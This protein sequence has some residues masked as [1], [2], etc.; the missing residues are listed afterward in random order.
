VLGI[1]S[2]QNT[3]TL[4]STYPTLGLL[5]IFLFGLLSCSVP[6]TQITYADEPAKPIE[7]TIL[8]LNDVYEIAPLEG[9]KVGGLA[10]VATVL[11]RLEAENPNTIAVMAGD[12]LSP[13]F[14]GTLRKNG[15]KVAGQQ[16]IE[17][18][19]ILGLDYATFG[20]HEFDF[21]SLELLESRIDMSDFAYVSTNA[22]VVRP[23]AGPVPFTQRGVDVPDYAIQEFRD[24]EGQSVRVALVGVLLPFAQQDYLEYEDITTTFRDGVMDAR[25]NADVVIGLTHLNIG[26]DLQLAK[27][28]PGL[29]L[30]M[31]GHEHEN[32]SHY[33]GNTVIAKADANA[34][35]V[36]VHHF[37]Y[38][39]D[40][41]ITQLRSELVP[42]NSSIPEDAATKTVVDQWLAI[43]DTLLDEMGYVA[44]DVLTTIDYVLE[45]KEVDVRNRQTNYGTLTTEAFRTAAPGAAAYLINSG[46]LRLDD[47]LSGTITEYDVLRTFPFGGPI[48]K[49]EMS[50]KNLIDL[51]QTGTVK[52]QG[53]GGYLQVL[54]PKKLAN[55]SW[56]IGDKAIENEENY[57]VVLPEFLAQGKESNLGFLGD[58]DYEK[59]VQLKGGLSNDIRDI[60]IAYMRSL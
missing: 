8:Q 56:T 43:Q 26:Q 7:F 28:V 3:A 27:D 39:P 20:N 17:T 12:F 23:D 16:M 34:K 31:G 6:K 9:G 38:Y 46:S 15:V 44:N 48:V 11:R 2:H 45:G 37:T 49:Q 10:R 29:P 35:T 18:L 53:E 60:V 58:I 25:Q 40:C 55:G 51:L 33:V 50:G 5:S 30:F 32:S 22:R 19:N 13:S 42:I 14:V 47:N 41:G 36:Y 21:S 24:S 52:N 54:G 4:K 59:P 57:L 1:A